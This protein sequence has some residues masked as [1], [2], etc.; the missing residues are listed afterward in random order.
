MDE[1]LINKWGGIG[2]LGTLPEDKKAELAVLYE[3]MARHILSLYIPE[4]S[5]GEKTAESSVFPIMYR[6]ISKGGY[7]S[8]VDSLYNDLVCFFDN[9]F[10]LVDDILRSTTFSI[11]VESE[12]SFMYIEHYLDRCKDPIKPIK[13]INR[14]RW[15]K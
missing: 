6:I 14:F 8:D 12:L 5:Y 13:K 11:D 3:L 9:S 4:P 1:E 7:I 10:L 2:L 15:M